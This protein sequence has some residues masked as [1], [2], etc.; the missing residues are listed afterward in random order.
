MEPLP[1][2]AITGSLAGKNLVDSGVVL[3]I[4]KDAMR[5]AG[6]RGFE[7]SVVIPDDSCRIALGP[8][9]NTGLFPA[10]GNF[11]RERPGAFLNSM[12]RYNECTRAAV[13]GTLSILP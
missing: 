7:M 12:F 6:V 4:T 2:D 9:Q 5:R 10:G 1:A 13:G 8:E 3:E 11:R